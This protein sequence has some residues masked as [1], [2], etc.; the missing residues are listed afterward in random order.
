MKHLLSA[1]ILAGVIIGTPAS[2]QQTFTCKFGEGG[3]P[4]RQPIDKACQKQLAP[5]V[6]VACGVLFDTFLCIYSNKQLAVTSAQLGASR[7]AV[8]KSMTD[9][10]YKAGAAISPVGGT[11]QAAFG[12]YYVSCEI[13]K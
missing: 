12:K 6:H 11:L 2:A 13:S 8:L 10:K 7:S 3:E 4:C 5:D 1:T 9:A